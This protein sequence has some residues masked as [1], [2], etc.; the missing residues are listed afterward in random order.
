[1]QP[2]LEGL[3]RQLPHF[4]SHES[5]HSGT[6]GTGIAAYESWMTKPRPAGGY[7]TSLLIQ[8][9]LEG[10]EEVQ[11]SLGRTDPDY[12]N[13]VQRDMRRADEYGESSNFVTLRNTY[14]MPRTSE[15]L[16]LVR[17]GLE[18]EY[19]LPGEESILIYAHTPL[20]RDALPAT[21]VN[22][23]ALLGG[24][25]ASIY[26]EFGSLGLARF[27]MHRMLSW[28]KSGINL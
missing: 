27:N 5:E 16:D 25:A 12:I 19:E 17:D 11:V 7:Y 1:M 14:K 9:R 4:A 15:T 2:A 3:A 22:V 8:P 18:D 10:H 13:I 23:H 6:I 28:F 26:E 24:E 21:N 20:E